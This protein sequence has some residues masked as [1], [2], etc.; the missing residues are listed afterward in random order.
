MLL[1]RVQFGQNGIFGGGAND[2]IHQLAVLEEEQGGDGS[3]I[4]AAS[5]PSAF[6]YID[7]TNFGGA[8]FFGCD[9]VDN[10]GNHLAWTT[11]WG[12]KV[13]EDGNIGGHYFAIEVIFGNNQ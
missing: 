3:H 10:G 9:L 8:C 5:N 4:V 7:L 6:I 12:P 1:E 13:D 11:P 2:G